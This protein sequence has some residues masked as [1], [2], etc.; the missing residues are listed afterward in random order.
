MC[1]FA[2]LQ[3]CGKLLHPGGIRTPDFL[4][5]DQASLPLDHGLLNRSRSR[6]S[7]GRYTISELFFSILH[8]SIFI[9][10]LSHVTSYEMASH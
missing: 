5:M 6:L 2:H 7:V 4:F 9:L 10:F 8:L 1:S 3:N